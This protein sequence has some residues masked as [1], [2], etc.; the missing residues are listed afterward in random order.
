MTTQDSQCDPMSDIDAVNIREKLLE[1]CNKIEEEKEKFELL[2]TLQSKGLITR[3]IMSFVIK[4]S[5]IRSHDRWPDKLTARR[6]MS[7]KISDSYKTLQIKR[8]QGRVI[9]N[10][11]LEQ[12]GN[13]K[14]KLRS[15]VKSIRQEI[16]GSDR[17]HALTKKNDRKIKHLQKIQSSMWGDKLPKYKPSPVPDR[18]KEYASLPIFK[19]PVDMPK[20]QEL[21]GP[22]ICH[23]GIKLDQNELK[24]LK[25]DPKFSLMDKCDKE[26]FMVENELSIAKHR[27]GLQESKYDQKKDKIVCVPQTPNNNKER[28][29]PDINGVDEYSDKNSGVDEY[30]DKNNVDEY[31]DTKQLE[32][33]WAKESHR[34]PFDPFSKGLDFRFRRPTDYKLNKRVV[35]PKSL[36]DTQE[37]LCEVKRRGFIQ[38]YDKFEQCIKDKKGRAPRLKPKLINSHMFQDRGLT[39]D[40]SRPEKE[41]TVLG[42]NKNKKKKRGRRRKSNRTNN[43]DKETYQNLNR[44]EQAGLDSILKRVNKNEI[45]VTPTDKSG[46]FAILTVDQYLKSGEVHTSKDER[47][48]WKQVN[49]LRNQVNNH[50]FW[51]RRILKYCDKTNSD[52]MNANLVVSDNDLP[53]MAILIKDH[54][55]W[56]YESNKPPP[57]RPVVSGNSTVNTHLSELISEIVEPLALESDGAEIQSSEEALHLLDEHNKRVLNGEEINILD[58]YDRLTFYNGASDMARQE[59]E[60]NARYNAR[61]TYEDNSSDFR[62]NE[63]DMRLVEGDPAPSD[64]GGV[65]PMSSS[66]QKEMGETVNEFEEEEFGVNLETDLID[67]AGDLQGGTI[68]LGEWKGDDLNDSDDSTIDVLSELLR[69]GGLARIDSDN[70]LH[71]TKTTLHSTETSLDIHEKDDKI[72]TDTQSRITDFFNNITEKEEKHEPMIDR[73]KNIMER[74]CRDKFLSS[75]E[76]L[77]YRLE[78]GT[79]AGDFWQERTKKLREK[80]Q[81]VVNDMFDSVPPIQDSCGDPVMIGCDVVGLYPNLDPVN[82]GRLTAD[83]VRSTRVKFRG[84]DFYTLAIYLLLVLGE[85]TMRKIG[86]GDCIPTRRNKDMGNPQ[87]LSSNINRNSDNWDYSKMNLTESNKREMIAYMLQLMVLLMTSTTCYKFGGKIYRQRKGLGIGLR[88]SAALARLIMCKWDATWAMIMK[89]FRLTLMIFYRYVDDIR[90]CLRPINKGWF[91][92]S[93]KWVFDAR[94]PDS[95]DA[96]TRTIEEIGKS[97]NS[98]WDFLEFTTESQR[99]FPDSSLP[100]LDF[101]TRIKSNGYVEYEFF[102]KPMSRNTVLT[103]GTALSRSCV[104]SSLR[105][106][107]V[108]RLSNTDHSLGTGVRLQIINQFIQLTINSG[109]RFPFVKSVVLQALSKYVYMVGRNALPPDHKLYSPLHRSVTYNSNR[110]KLCKYTEQATWYSTRIRKDIHSNGWK[111]W[112]TSKEDRR[113][114]RQRKKIKFKNNGK[115]YSTDNSTVIFVPKTH[116]ETL[117]K[118]LQES[119]EKLAHTTGWGTKLIEKPG[120]PL[121]CTFIKPFPM[122]DGCTRGP[123][124]Y[125]CD[126]KGTKCMSKNVVYQAVCMTCQEH[127]SEHQVDRRQEFS[128]IGETSRQ[129]G[130][131][132]GEHMENLNKWKKESFILD[133]WMECHALSTKPPTFSFRV[134]SKHKDAL[135]RQIKEAVLIKV[136]GNLNKK[137]EF[138]SNEL[139]RL[140]SRKYSWEQCAEDKAM[141]KK[142]K[143]HEVKVEDFINVMRNVSNVNK[144]K[145]TETHIDLASSSRSNKVSNS[146]SKRKRMNTSTPVHYRQHTQQESDSS[147]IGENSGATMSEASSGASPSMVVDYKSTDPGVDKLLDGKLKSLLITPI[148]MEH[149]ALTAAREAIAANETLDSSDFFRKRINSL[150][151]GGSI[152]DLGKLKLKPARSATLDEIDFSSWTSGEK[153]DESM[154]ISPIGLNEVFIDYWIGDDG[155]YGLGD[156]FLNEEEVVEREVEQLIEYKTKNKLYEIFIKMCPGRTTS[157]RRRSNYQATTGGAGVLV[158]PGKRKFSPQP[159][160]QEEG[161]PTKTACH[162]PD[163]GIIKRSN[164]ISGGS[165]GLGLSKKKNKLSSSRRRL[166]SNPDPRQQRLT[167]LWKKNNKDLDKTGSM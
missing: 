130:T 108:R 150:P 37:F 83:A 100:T 44:D 107:L 61:N 114:N 165:S 115:M 64:G 160:L 87:S 147:P 117:I 105:Q 156:L 102:S 140:E 152:G 14:Y 15:L 120:T 97:I 41:E 104:F 84:I 138:A 33:L 85:S 67:T 146:A 92:E 142:E 133:H 63:N 4:Q 101:K 161:N 39:R 29:S 48:N 80:Q 145:L 141:R 56:K 5:K 35:L 62:Q 3:D 98:V 26:T 23:P 78:Q 94:K 136:K 75:S 139:I 72:N 111:R 30:S 148:K 112:I 1:I 153:F 68:A 74:T 12:L 51:F 21:V 149:K 45:R 129:I 154:N 13:K 25:K 81:T 69:E 59:L 125:M 47:I 73:W 7:A 34:F 143:E 132:V 31:S 9:K 95:R 124:C 86:L 134:I 49:Y 55:D 118:M 91:W 32:T 119:E 17:H 158:T 16:Q 79:K 77:R 116:D 93:G 122:E 11:C 128:Y 166:M 109:H 6:A 2:K 99:D 52:R 127:N 70:H 88:G 24:I 40:V 46:R 27:Y 90:L 38:T 162:S 19:L 131:R 54:K 43:K 65:F 159:G 76:Q 126:N 151:A 8:N 66:N 157:A 20:P 121:L 10:K 135:S 96:V 167:T 57:S 113:G 144:R 106:D 110:R 137:C 22:F 18:L 164:S 42:K 50:M 53:E 89:N 58:N 103:Y 155:T 71:R 123:D 36:D 28:Y 82:A 163:L 60:S